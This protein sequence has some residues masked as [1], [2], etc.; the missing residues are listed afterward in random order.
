MA[1]TGGNNAFNFGSQNHSIR[2]TLRRK[3]DP[4]KMNYKNLLGKAWAPDLQPRHTRY[5]ADNNPLQMEA[6]LPAI[7]PTPGRKIE[8]LKKYYKERIQDLAVVYKGAHTGR[9]YSGHVN[10]IGDLQVVGSSPAFTKWMRKQY[11]KTH[12]PGAVM[13]ADYYLRA[14]A[15]P[16]I[17]RFIKTSQAKIEAYSS[18]IAQLNGAGGAESVLDAYLRGFHSFLRGRPTKEHQEKLKRLGF[19]PEFEPFREESVQQYLRAFSKVKKD[20]YEDLAMLRMQ[21]P[22]GDIRQIELFYKYIVDAKEDEKVERN[23]W[24]WLEGGKLSKYGSRLLA[25]DHTSLVDQLY[26]EFP[27][28]TEPTKQTPVR[29]ALFMPYNGGGGGGGGDG[30]GGGGDDGGGYDETPTDDESEEDR[31]A[32]ARR[33]QRMQLREARERSAHRAGGRGSA[34]GSQQT[35]AMVVASDYDDASA[36]TLQEVESMDE[37]PRS[38]Q[39]DASNVAGLYTAIAEELNEGNVPTE[40]ALRYAEAIKQGEGRLAQVVR[41]Y[42]QKVPDDELDDAKTSISAAR[43]VAEDALMRFV[44]RQRQGEAEEV[45][46]GAIDDNEDLDDEAEPVGVVE[47]P[48]AQEQVPPPTPASEAP[49][50]PVADSVEPTPSPE[51]K[52]VDTSPPSSPAEPLAE[53][54]KAEEKSETPT[55]TPSTTTT[56]ESRSPSPSPARSEESP[57]SSPARVEESNAPPTNNSIIE[58]AVRMV[59]ATAS[60]VQAAVRSNQPGPVH[61]RNIFNSETHNVSKQEG[62]TVTSSLFSALGRPDQGERAAALIAQSD[63]TPTPPG[64]NALGNAAAQNARLQSEVD[65]MREQLDEKNLDTEIMTRTL[66]EANRERDSAKE[67][68]KE[69]KEQVR[70]QQNLLKEEQERNR[71]LKQQYNIAMEAKEAAELKMRE[72]EALKAAADANAQDMHAQLDEFYRKRYDNLLQKAETEAQA[73]MT[74]EAQK[75][76][77]EYSR[78]NRELR[79]L[80]ETIASNSAS[81]DKV[82]QT[83]QQTIEDQ[84]RQLQETISNQQNNEATKVLRAVEAERN[85][86][87]LLADQRVLAEQKQLQAANI[88]VQRLRQEIS[89]YATQSQVD[90]A[91]VSELT[92]QLTAA[93]SAKSTAET[94]LLEAQSDNK[95]LQDALDSATT[96]LNQTIQTLR[97]ENQDLLTK[98]TTAAREALARAEEAEKEAKGA[99]ERVAKLELDLSVAKKE[100]EEATQ[101]AKD[102][103]IDEQTQRAKALRDRRAL[104][105][106]TDEHQQLA[107]AVEQ[108]RA[109]HQ[110]TK[111]KLQE[112]AEAAVETARVAQERLAEA[113]VKAQETRQALR[114]RMA[115]SK[116]GVDRVQAVKRKLD[117]LQKAEIAFMNTPAAEVE[118]A[119]VIDSGAKALSLNP[120]DK[121]AGAFSTFGRML[122]GALGYADKRQ[123]T[124]VEPPVTE[125]PT[126]KSQVTGKNLFSVAQTGVNHAKAATGGG[127]LHTLESVREAESVGGAGSSSGGSGG[128][129]DDQEGDGFR[130]PTSE[131]RGPVEEAEVPA[132]VITEEQAEAY[133]DFEAGVHRLGRE[134]VNT[135]AG[136]I[137]HEP[138]RLKD[139]LPILPVAENSKTDTQAK[140]LAEQLVPRV[141]SPPPVSPT[142]TPSER[143]NRTQRYRSAM[144]VAEDAPPS[145]QR[146]AT[147]STKRKLDFQEDATKIV[148]PNEAADL[149]EDLPPRMF[150]KWKERFD[151]TKRERPFAW[152]DDTADKKHI[153]SAVK[154]QMTPEERTHY[155]GIQADELFDS[156]DMITAL[157]RELEEMDEQEAS[158]RGAQRMRTA[159][160][161]LRQR[162]PNLEDIIK[163]FNANARK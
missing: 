81:A 136:R 85:A 156:A 71:T 119:Q 150:N 123:R 122:A 144:N 66:E 97:K 100:A 155:E 91:K 154:E 84:A 115:E 111:T 26:G 47:A 120:F 102:A 56:E 163:R 148:R 58:A 19:K 50:P 42:E 128:G 138:Y 7:E 146:Q 95:R 15:A 17:G 79:A 131:F 22:T 147:G 37:E 2:K 99:T 83:L 54:S 145:D 67:R 152:R 103:E 34:G 4:I 105:R 129:G 142:A 61:V 149:L 46:N 28:G 88:E 140:V 151:N 78:L 82:R 137:S 87:L 32:Q 62:A 126:L 112:Y 124:E 53:P 63:Q 20:Y 39:V 93:I 135:G 11:E 30:G 160:E 72:N 31:R 70:H 55:T 106:K 35:D 96:P 8:L 9:N 113:Q 76:T 141:Q 36:P 101:K 52:S 16:Y 94:G 59:E 118:D 64:Y 43:D 12:P 38:L 40:Q 143:K 41:Q 108:E 114:V 3:Y 57:A 29:Q 109:A 75:A 130:G 14:E 24:D 60:A 161:R 98:Q 104:K 21:G 77:A 121:A 139:G 74:A 159:L 90:G 23:L 133:G 117:D 116:Q 127:I 51:T 89:D 157:S 25:P 10:D 1:Q 80:Q 44:Q 68:A 27:V 18:I 153:V 69:M 125:L 107:K 13:P 45:V 73:R 86:Q 158:S 92:R 5:R 110:E 48:A 49:V 65:R 162:Y 33:A 6:S 132:T 134:I